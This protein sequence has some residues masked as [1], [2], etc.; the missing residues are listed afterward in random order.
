MKKTI[1]AI[2]ITLLLLSAIPLSVIG[3]G[4][5][6]PSQYS[7]TYYGELKHMYNKLYSAQGKKI[8]IIGNSSVAFGVDSAL[9]E[10]HLD[11]YTVC[12]FGLYGTLGT[13]LMLDL[14]LDAI[15]EGDVVV[16]ATE[17]EKQSLSMYY[18]AMHA[19][20]AMDA[21]FGMLNRVGS[22]NTAEMV[23]NFATYTAEKLQRY[24]SPK[25][26]VS[27]IYAQSSFDEDCVMRYPREY[28][29]MSGMYDI[30]VII[31]YEK[32]D[33][34]FVT[35]LNDYAA[36]VSKK[37]GKTFFGFSPVNERAVSRDETADTI[38]AYFEYLCDTLDFDVIGTPIDYLMNAGYFY[39]SNFHPNDAGMVVHTAR[40]IDDIKTA[41]A[42]ST[43]TNIDL[44]APP[45]VP[46]GGGDEEEGNNEDA[47]LFEYSFQTV[48]GERVAVITALKPE[49]ASRES[50]VVPYSYDG[51][52]VQ[53]FMPRVFAGNTTLRS[54][55]VQHNVSVI[56]DRSFDGCS[57]LTALNMTTT[58][59]S[60]VNV[61]RELLSGADSCT[62]YV[63]AASYSAYISDYFWGFYSARVE[64]ISE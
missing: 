25:T 44:P 41:L 14:S 51:A 64:V 37:G 62:I 8:V 11:G 5:G 3:V 23:G 12:N 40:L 33:P 60:T 45:E 52:I 13:K 35:Y 61:A 38:N 20:Y 63:P 30:N 18:S 42:I 49:A 56:S 21:D 57:S 43:P 9:M 4:F 54:V 15:G 24:S 58:D 34:E 16:I 26:E 29:K 7:E 10:E 55:T 1:V 19:W 50:I 36:A 28:N 17:Q 47:D 59:P 22:D 39:D 32:I 46:E 48:G 27:G 2:L 31:E 53:R 6:L